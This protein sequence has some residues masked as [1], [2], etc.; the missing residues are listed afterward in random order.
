M[1][2]HFFRAAK[3]LEVATCLIFAPLRF[4][5]GGFFGPRVLLRYSSIRTEPANSTN[6]APN[7]RGV[8]SCHTT[9]SSSGIAIIIPRWV[10]WISSAT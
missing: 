1:V 4:F 5:G 10:I 6:T 7:S 2:V 3:I 8:R 9:H